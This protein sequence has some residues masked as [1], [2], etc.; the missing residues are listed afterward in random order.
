VTGKVL[1]RPRGRSRGFGCVGV[2][3]PCEGRSTPARL[4]SVKRRPTYPDEFLP[5]VRLY[6]DDITDICNVLHEVCKRIAI[7]TP[8]YESIEPSELG[9]LPTQALREI[10][11]TGFD[12]Y[13]S[14]R[15]RSRTLLLTAGGNDITS[16]GVMQKTKE[17]LLRRRRPILRWLTGNAGVRVS[18]GM[19]VITFVVL[20]AALTTP[21]KPQVRYVVAGF[22]ILG[23]VTL[24]QMAVVWLAFRGA[25][26]VILVPRKQA[27][28]FWQRNRDAIVVNVICAVIG[29]VAGA[30]A[31]VITLHAMGH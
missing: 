23:A 3:A 26:W 19:S 1:G 7:E 25:N 6:L 4:A 18:I 16:L 11:I 2:G 5:P 21:G 8:E 13:I 20:I 30:V 27:P 12:P 31:T 22:L 10:T 14:V 29:A 17:V 15:V 28:N 24:G 9:N